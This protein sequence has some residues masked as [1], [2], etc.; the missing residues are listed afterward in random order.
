MDL[1]EKELNDCTVF[2]RIDA[3][4]AYVADLSD[5]HVGADGHHKKEFDAVVNL[6]AEIPNFYVIIGGDST[7]SSGLATKSSVFDENKH[8]IDQI[9]DLRKRLRPIKDRILFI[10]SGN[11]GFER[12]MKA[13]KIPPEHV[14]AELL[15]VPFFR[16]FGAAIINARKNAYVLATN[17]TN[18]NAH[19]LEW[20]NTDVLFMEHKHIKGFQ[21]E[22]VAMANKF[23]K[24]WMVRDR[25][26]VQTGSFLSWAGYAKDRLYR[27]QYVGTPIVELS[28]IRDKWDMRVYER[29]EDFLRT[30]FPAK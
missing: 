18:Q 29:T 1:V 23:T 19:K 2:K 12:S 25:L 3:D 28:G 21:R 4:Y 9:I 13:N 16:G 8:G 5:V 14:L 27:P 10:R 22:T 6:I 11:H 24:K 30:V 17:H 26:V 7:E 15:E 20:L